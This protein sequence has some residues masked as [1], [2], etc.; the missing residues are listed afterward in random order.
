MKKLALAYISCV[1]FF[2]MGCN[3]RTPI[4][5]K[6]IKPIDF[7]VHH[8]E[9]CFS[10]AEK[11]LSSEMERTLKLSDDNYFKIFMDITYPIKNMN[12]TM[13]GYRANLYWSKNDKYPQVCIYGV[14]V[15]DYFSQRI[16]ESTEGMKFP[17]EFQKEEILEIAKKVTHWKLV[18]FEA[19]LYL[20]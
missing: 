16:K 4:I 11:F 6:E 9:L 2:A 7:Y 1:F 14:G 3:L 10:V 5:E 13:F 20:R 17:P 18:L 19:I 15:A 8:G 12:Y